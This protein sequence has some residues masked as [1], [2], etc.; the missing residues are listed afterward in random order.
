VFHLCSVLSVLQEYEWEKL[1]LLASKLLEESK[2]LEN[3]LTSIFQ[4]V[5]E[6]G[7]QSFWSLYDLKNQ[8]R[9]SIFKFNPRVNFFLSH[10]H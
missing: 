1:L 2:L 3:I 8:M 6:I 7:S 10:I 4:C 9:T 5:L